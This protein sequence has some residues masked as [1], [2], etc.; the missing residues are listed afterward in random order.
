MI[1]IFFKILDLLGD[2][3]EVCVSVFDLKTVAL[4]REQFD[5]TSFCLS[6]LFQI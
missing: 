4:M 6:N 2:R 1:I 3:L 5:K